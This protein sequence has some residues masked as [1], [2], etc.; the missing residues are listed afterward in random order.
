MSIKDYNRRLERL[1]KGIK[2]YTY[3]IIFFLTFSFFVFF[4][5]RQ[6][7]RTAFS[8][9]RK[10]EDLQEVDAE[11]E[12]I[13][14]DIVSIQNNMEEIRGVSDLILEA[15]PHRP[16]INSVI[17]DIK[18]SVDNNDLKIK[19]I[20]IRRIS[21]KGGDRKK[22]KSFNVELRLEGDFPHITSFLKDIN[23]Q[24][25]MKLV[26]NLT[27]ESIEKVGSS[28]GVLKVS[29]EVNSFFL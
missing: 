5:I 3:Q 14:G 16:R 21:L 9:K 6:T 12:K 23:N 11:Y 19:Q 17:N 1:K 24:L 28:S 8:V 27:I 7:L 15:L 25:R 29:L 4:V 13:V 18:T 2:D 26:N 10:L 20:E 22:E